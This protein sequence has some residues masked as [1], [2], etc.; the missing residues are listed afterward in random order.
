MPGLTVGASYLRPGIVWPLRGDLYTSLSYQFN[1]NNI[2]YSGHYDVTNAPLTATDRA[3]TNR[4]EARLGVGIP[5]ATFL[6]VIPYLAAGYQSW[7]RNVDQSG[8]QPVAYSDE[9]YTGRLAG[10]GVKLDAALTPTLV[11]SAD[12]EFLGVVGTHITYLDNHLGSSMGASNEERLALGL[13]DALYGPLHVFGNGFWEHYT[14][15]G[16]KPDTASYGGL[17][18]LSVTQEFGVNVGASYAF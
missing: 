5:V 2:T 6:E 7:N 15:S 9:Q 18:P 14:W 8:P 1:A 3:V 16:S 12:A 4:L 11:A 10:A 13:D 17:E